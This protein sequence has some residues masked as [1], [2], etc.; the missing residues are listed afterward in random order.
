MQ[1]DQPLVEEHPRGLLDEERVALGGLG[2]ARGD[3]R[4]DVVAEQVRNQCAGRRLRERF[5][6]DGPRRRRR[7]Q[8]REHLGQIGPRRADDEDRRAAAELDQVLDEAQECEL[9]PVQVVEE[10]EHRPLPRQRFE[11]AADRPGDLLRSR[12]DVV[13]TDRAGEPRDDEARLRHIGQ[14]REQLLARRVAG[15]AVLDPR[16]RLQHD[17]EREVGDALAVR[18]TAALEHRR[19][20]ADDGCELVCEP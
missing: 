15:V 5:E 1:R 4:R 18:D 2:D 13:E 10:D 20:L 8:E 16:E 17:R 9:G 7:R 6:H 12:E 3:L 11:Q 19:A 14:E